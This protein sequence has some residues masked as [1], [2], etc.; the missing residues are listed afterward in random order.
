M[1]VR[2]LWRKF[3]NVTMGPDTGLMPRVSRAARE[4][5]LWALSRRL[6]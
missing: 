6:K 3:T 5:D 4:G 2:P 1:N